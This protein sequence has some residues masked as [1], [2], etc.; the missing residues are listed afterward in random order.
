MA[1]HGALRRAAVCA[2]D[3]AAALPLGCCGAPG[4]RDM[5]CGR[6]GPSTLRVASSPY[7]KEA[8]VHQ[9]CTKPLGV[10]QTRASVTPRCPARPT[11]GRRNVKQ[12]KDGVRKVVADCEAHSGDRFRPIA[13]LPARHRARVMG[14]RR[15]PAVPCAAFRLSACP[16]RVGPGWPGPR[17]LGLPTLARRPGSLAD[18]DGACVQRPTGTGSRPDPDA[19][20]RCDVIG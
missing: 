8:P 14:P 20:P 18:P 1:L 16:A 11:S 17:P 19:P 4:R 13:S 15:C 3:R 9:W 6:Q 10:R 12:R 5:C 7:V 2:R